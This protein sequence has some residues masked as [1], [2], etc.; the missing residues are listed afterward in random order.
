MAYKKTK[1]RK[2]PTRKTKRKTK[3]LVGAAVDLTAA[4]MTLGVGM[5]L[6]R[7]AM[8]MARR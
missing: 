7:S 8:N 5:G 6:T 3:K 1:Q 4:G 2:C